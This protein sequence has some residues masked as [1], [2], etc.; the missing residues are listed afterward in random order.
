MPEKAIYTA[1]LKVPQAKGWR[2]LVL[3]AIK[4]H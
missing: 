1:K 3:C 4:T 2:E